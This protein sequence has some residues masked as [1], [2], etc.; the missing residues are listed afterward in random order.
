MNQ[1]ELKEIL[2]DNGYE[3][4]ILFENPDFAS[5][6]IGVTTDEIAVYNYRKMIE[7]L[8]NVSEMTEEEAEEYINYNTIRAL[9]Y[10]KK[11]PVVVMD[12]CEDF[13]IY[14]NNKKIW[15]KKNLHL[16]KQKN[17]FTKFTKRRW[18]MNLKK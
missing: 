12:L 3:D 8:V 16:K 17:S 13:E 1:K 10:Y 11:S 18:G 15:K 7:H 9:P 6:F 4:V 14:I 2:V 5:A